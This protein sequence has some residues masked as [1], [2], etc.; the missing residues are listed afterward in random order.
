MIIIGFW[1]DAVVDD[2]IE[3]KI[4]HP[5]MSSSNPFYIAY[6]NVAHDMHLLNNL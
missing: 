5:R 6:S 3:Q 1:N 2:E 4:V